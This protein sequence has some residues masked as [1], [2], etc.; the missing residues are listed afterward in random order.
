MCAR[1][2]EQYV[3]REDGRASGVELCSPAPVTASDHVIIKVAF[4]F[5]GQGTVKGQFVSLFNSYLPRKVQQMVCE[6]I[7]CDRFSE[8]YFPFFPSDTTD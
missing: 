6:F 3:L 5:L 4:E 1:K 8:M 7:K 2:S